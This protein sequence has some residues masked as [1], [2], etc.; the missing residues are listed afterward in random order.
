MIVQPQ[1]RDIQSLSKD[2]KQIIS[3]F[4]FVST[5]QKGENL[6]PTTSG[7]FCL[8]KAGEVIGYVEN[9]IEK[10]LYWGIGLYGYATGAYS[11]ESFDKVI[12][13]YKSE[14][15]KTKDIFKDTIETLTKLHQIDDTDDAKL[16]F[17]QLGKTA[18]WHVAASR[19][20]F[21]N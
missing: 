19:V 4:E 2:L 20:G 3:N 10:T 1:C 8:R 16:A 17:I 14:I 9:P 18:F 7:R 6:Q 15:V 21:H 5:L 12:T 13:H 11:K